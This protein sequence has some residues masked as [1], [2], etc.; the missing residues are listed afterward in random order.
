MVLPSL[1]VP[2]ERPEAE[3]QLR[4]RETAISVLTAAVQEKLPGYGP[5]GICAVLVTGANPDFIFQ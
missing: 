5:D 2:V 4:P 3:C 1:M